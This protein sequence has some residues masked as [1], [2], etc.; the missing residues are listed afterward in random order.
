MKRTELEAMWMDDRN[1]RF[2]F[3]IYRCPADPRMFVRKRDTFGWTLNFSHKAALPVS[4]LCSLRS[5]HP[6]P[7]SSCGAMMA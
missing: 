6:L 4:P 2:Y 3:T 1:W 7:S 5:F